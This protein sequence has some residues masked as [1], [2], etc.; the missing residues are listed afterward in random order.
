M[1][2]VVLIGFM[3]AGKSVVGQALARAMRYTLWDTD[4]IVERDAGRTIAEIWEAD[5]E[6][7]FR[8]LE[9]EAV[10]SAAKG[11]R[12]VIACGGGAIL[13]LRNYDVLKRSGTVV[14]LR[15]PA[16]T[17]RERVKAGAGRPL[18][19][20]PRAFDE[21]LAQRLPAYESAADVVIDTFGRPP[22]DIASEISERLP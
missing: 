17:L 8:D 2:N 21:L 4:A 9:H 20:D 10:I 5:G 7:A 1:S 15:A 11:D 3:G 18:L 16:A 19:K 12:R 13:Q 14:Y 6:E 22:E